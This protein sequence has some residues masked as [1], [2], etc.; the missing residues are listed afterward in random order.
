MTL[1]N[2]G[3]LFVYLF[4]L[5]ATV[6]ALAQP[7]PSITQQPSSQS[8][9]A[10][11]NAT[12]TVTATGQ[13]LSYFWQLN[14]T[15]LVND[16]YVSGVNSPTLSLSAVF[17]GISDGTY[18]VI[19]S[20]RHGMVTSDPAV[21]TVLV[22]ASIRTHPTA[23]S[24]VLS[25]NAT[26]SANVNG[27][28]PI[29][30][31]WRRNGTDLVNDGR[32]SGATTS[33][34]TIANTLASDAGDYS[35]FVSNSVGQ[36]T[37][38]AAALTVQIPATIDQSPVDQS[39]TPGT[40]VI[41]SV[42]ASGD[43]PLSFQWFHY[44]SALFDDG[45]ITGA[46]TA[47][48]SIANFGTND[49]GEYHVIVSNS[50]GSATSSVA[51]L[52]PLLPPS[53]I[54]HPQ[55]QTV[56][57]GRTL[58]LSANVAGT[59]PITYQW[60]FNGLPI[61]NT[62]RI[63][64]VDTLNLTIS[65][66]Q[67]AD[68]G[69]YHLV[70]SNAYGIEPSLVATV[71]VLIPPAFTSQPE[72][73]TINVGEPFSFSTAVNGS[74][75]MSYQWFF[76]GA[77]LVD[78]ERTYGSTTPNL[79]V[80]SSVQTDQ[81]GYTLVASNSVGQ[82]TSSVA[83]LIVKV[84]PSFVSQPESKTVTNGNSIILSVSVSGTQPF[85]YQWYYYGNPL[86]NGGRVA[87]VDGH[88]LIIN[89]AQPSDAGDYFVVV[90]NTVGTVTSEIATVTVVVP[91]SFTLHATNQT[92]LAN[93]TVT[94][95]TLVEGTEP[96]DFQWLRNGGTLVNDSLLSGVK[97]TTLTISNISSGYAG[98]FQ[99]RAS[100][101]AGVT[102]SATATV[103][104]LTP[105]SI[106]TQPKGR[107]A[108]AGLLTTFSVAAAGTSPLSYQWLRNG[109]PIPGATGMSHGIPQVS[110]NSIGEYRVVV[111]N[112]FG[113]TTSAVA[114]LT[115]GPVAAWGRDTSNECLPPP[116][117]SNVCAV[118]GQ[119]GSSLI[120][121]HDGY[122]QSWGS[123]NFTVNGSV[124]GIAADNSY[125]LLRNDGTMENPTTNIVKVA[126]GWNHRLGLSREGVVVAFGSGPGTNV[127]VGLRDVAA[128]AAGGSH[129]LALRSN[130]TVV[131]WG[132]TTATNVPV[133]LVNVVAIAAGDF[134]SLALKSDGTM[135]AWGSPNYTAIP[136][137]INTNI[138]AI[139]IG[140][141]PQGTAHTLALR[142]NGTV[143]AWGS[144][145]YGQTNVPFGLSNVI[146]IAGAP[147]HSLA[148]VGDGKPVL[149]RPP[150]GG[151][152]YEGTPFVLSTEV[153]GQKPLHYQWFRSDVPLQGATNSSFTITN[154]TAGL[155]YSYSVLVSN[156]L[157]SVRSIWVPVSGIRTA[158]QIL[159]IP[160]NL[161]VRFGSPIV[162]DPVVVGSEPIRYQWIFNNTNLVNATNRTLVIAHAHYTNAGFY[163]LWI[164]NS[165]GT[166][167]SAPVV[168]TVS[169]PVIAWGAFGGQSTNVPANLTNAIAISAGWSHALA[170][171]DDGT[172][173]A[174]GSGGS[175][176]VP[177]G[178]SNVVEIAAGGNQ[179][180]ALR[181][182][183]SIVVWGNYY[184]TIT[185]SAFVSV[186]ADLYGLSCLRPDGT[187][188]RSGGGSSHS[189][190]TNIVALFRF[191]DGHFGV[192]GNGDFYYVGSGSFPSATN[193]NI[194][195]IGA[196]RY[197]GLLLKRDTSVHSY[198]APGGG[199][200]NRMTGAI[201]VASTTAAYWAIRQDGTA[202]RI[203]G[204]DGTTNAP[205]DLSG[206][207]VIDS[208]SSFCV[209]L[210]TTRELHPVTLSE[211]TDS[212]NLVVSSKGS[213]QWFGQTNITHDGMDAAQSAEIGRN[214]ASSMRMFVDG[215]VSI[216]FW[217]KV[218]SQT[219]S[220]SLTFL[221][222]G[223]P[224]ASISGEVGWQQRTIAIPTGRQIVAWTY[225]KDNSGTAGSDAAWVD[226]IE[227]V[228]APPVIVT[229]PNSAS[230]MRGANVTFMT[231]V[232][233]TP[234][235]SFRWYK[236]GN[237][238]YLGTASS[239]TLNLVTRSH[240]G[241]YFVVVTNAGGS[242]I[243]SNAVLKVKAPQDIDSVF[244][245]DGVFTMRSFDQGGLSLSPSDLSSFTAQ[246][247]TNLAIWTN[248]PNSLLSITNGMLQ[249]RDPGYTNNPAQYYR[250]IENW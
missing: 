110:S 187:V 108:P 176:N 181:R 124:V 79:S 197:Q 129:S 243:S 111:T 51:F 142:S 250:I 53:F 192:R 40:N 30:Y 48:L 63:F 46:L 139:A 82:A 234:P 102:L 136:T 228:P 106:T 216:R 190:A 196:S 100:N 8:V 5:I 34:L 94:L 152:Q 56:T 198:S 193:R 72:S 14:G 3:I 75:P 57:N 1:R 116:G 147:Y 60:F 162:I 132:S 165:V 80:S 213:P 231:S 65:N 43:S 164:S 36:A 81:G 141:Y 104:V 194:T 219:N 149:L 229:Q 239:L 26:F 103:T 212:T 32:I 200:S 160:T 210:A 119:S 203:S 47:N 45:R 120:L 183:G 195:E 226:G 215:P 126:A 98:N 101:V 151:K 235:F 20:N 62:A 77:P 87:G 67:P 89:N 118:A 12:F 9:L 2:R 146:A 69:G 97:T 29:T 240:S 22:P 90:T 11:S 99:L 49:A 64:G 115:V 148:L 68:A 135:V 130:G 168:V 161:N 37:S 52:T 92:V 105:P 154:T 246:A 189:S 13:F 174:W 84:P 241:T 153:A 131:A 28:Q 157:G 170:L 117:L 133:G 177:V 237:P 6:S 150:V 182:D 123:A 159:S 199:T 137:N 44:D 33:A 166:L 202:V 58:D 59:D 93:S 125:T 185:N 248:L 39:A 138:A 206:L 134:H 145:T 140:S 73:Q 76:A 25:S 169:K 178:L 173:V 95:S 225:A 50:L 83:L 191:D 127:P 35:L 221:A 207:S 10:G 143:V 227:I 238:Q 224:L 245:E 247:S 186:E 19:V 24:V 17:P 70:A 74:E 218:S 211:G 223:I 233:G 16:T 217:W 167:T 230:V 114:L 122:Y 42:T 85:G 21:L 86:I 31:R 171:R 249:L 208:G 204:N 121:R 15:N 55:D 38:S 107:S 163:S 156:T 112:S 66:M 222:G 188:F 144:N 96:M 23:Q 113:S 54:S 109:V 41:L 7:T 88:T 78:N 220:D 175:T 158:P 91:P 18:Q 179:S 242:T 205:A 184:G 201:S 236:T 71:D 172:V 4:L 155:T 27:T 61:T 244:V 128:I 214:T 209:A 232:S 180:A